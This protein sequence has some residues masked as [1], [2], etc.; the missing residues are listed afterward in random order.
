MA[1]SRTASSNGWYKRD[2]WYSKGK[3]SDEVVP[4]RVLGG[5]DA[6]PDPAGTPCLAY[7]YRLGR[8]AFALHSRLY[9][10]Y[11]S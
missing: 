8:A 3:C 4:G 7:R 10:L 1:A 9:R 6:M 5:T 2:R 11:H